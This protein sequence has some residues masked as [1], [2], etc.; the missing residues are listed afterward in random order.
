MIKYSVQS[1]LRTHF[2]LGKFEPTRETMVRHRLEGLMMILHAGP[3]PS[4]K[5]HAKKGM[6]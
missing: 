5:C 2:Q 1:D 6:I 3:T 4:N